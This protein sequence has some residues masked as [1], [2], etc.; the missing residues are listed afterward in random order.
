MNMLE[1]DRKLAR[2]L[3]TLKVRI[4]VPDENTAVF[5]NVPVNRRY[6]NKSATNILVK[7]AAGGQAFVVCVDEDLEYLGRESSLCRAFAPVRK[8]NGWRMIC[9]AQAEDQFQV[10]VETALT[11]LGTDGREPFLPSHMN[12][13]GPGDGGKTLLDLHGVNLTEQAG[14]HAPICIGR[15]EQ[16]DEVVSCLLRWGQTKLAV[17]S[18]ESGVGKS[19]LLH[20]IAARLL[21]CRPQWR[22]ISVDMANLLSVALFE[23]EYDGLLARLLNQAAE[24]PDTILVLEHFELAMNILNSSLLLSNYLDKGR[25][26]LG[27][28]L[29]DHLHKLR[30]QCLLRRV[31]VTPL[32]ELSAD[33]VV[34]VIST[35]RPKIAEHY[36]IEIDDSCLLAAVRAAKPLAGTFPAKA[37]ALLDAAA[38][39]SA[40][41]QAKVLAADDLYAAA[42]KSERGWGSECSDER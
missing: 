8:Q 31:E 6:F 25:P 38:A 27:T 15:D 1:L 36:Q 21:T 40:L 42:E 22:V 33:Q 7:R 13:D 16:I 37:I 11:A 18:G 26:L 9:M 2:K 19:N 30:R 4:D 5:R 23:A 41:A 3:D 35:L 28:M 24:S 10:A 34:R 12:Q 29:P 20:A 17:V 39:R 32:P 14:Q